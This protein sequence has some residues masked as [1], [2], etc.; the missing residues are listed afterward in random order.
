MT[1]IPFNSNLSNIKVY[2]T[3]KWNYGPEDLDLNGSVGSVISGDS[4]PKA[5]LFVRAKPAIEGEVNPAVIQFPSGGTLVPQNLLEY[6]GFNQLSNTSRDTINTGLNVDGA[7][8]KI[9]IIDSYGSQWVQQDLDYFSQ[10]CGI[11]S[12]TI[13]IYPIGDYTDWDALKNDQALSAEALGWSLETALDVQYA[14]ALAPL[15]EINLYTTP[16][17][18][19][20]YIYAAIDH[21]INIL[22]V[23]VI[24][25][26]LGTTETSVFYDSNFD[27]VFNTLNTNIV[28]AAGD[29][30]VQVLYPASSPYV[31]SIGGTVL[32]GGTY[33]N[34]Y[35]TQGAYSESAWSGS[36]GGIST[37]NPRPDYQNNITITNS[38]TGRCV[39]D[40]AFCGG[41]LQWVVLTNTYDNTG[42]QS[43]WYRV[44]GTSASAP[45]W[46]AILA[47][48]HSAG[49]GNKNQR[50]IHSDLYSLWI[51]NSSYNF[52][53]ITVG[54]NGYPATIGFDFITGLGS[55]IVNHIIPSI[56]PTPT[57]TPT[58][59][60]TPT[61]TT[62]NTTTPTPSW[63]P[64]L[65]PSQTPTQTKTPTK[66]PITPKTTS[67]P[68]NTSTNG[69]LFLTPTPSN[70]PTK[71]PA[72]PKPTSTPTPTTTVT[73]TKGNQFL[74]PTPSNTPT[75]TP[76]TPKPTSTRTPTPTKTVTPTRTK[77]LAFTPTATNTP[78]QTKTP[79]RTSLPTKTPTP[80]RT[81]TTTQTPSPLSLTSKPS[82]Y[83]RVAT[84]NYYSV[85][86]AS[87]ASIGLNPRYINRNFSEISIWDNGRYAGGT[88]NFTTSAVSAVKTF[89][90]VVYA[91]QAAPTTLFNLKAYDSDSNTVYDII[92]RFIF[93]AG[94]QLGSAA[95]PVTF[96]APLSALNSVPITQTPTPTN[97]PTNT[98]TPT[99]TQ[100]QT[101]TTSNTPTPTPTNTLTPTS[102]PSPTLTQ[103]STPT[104]TNTQTPTSTQTPTPTNT[105]TPSNTPTKAPI[106]SQ[107]PTNTPT[108]SG[109]P[110]PTPTVT[111]TPTPTVTPTVTNTQ[112]PTNT[113]TPTPTNTSTPTPTVIPLNL[114]NKPNWTRTSFQVSSTEV[115]YI[116]VFDNQQGI[117]VN[118]NASELSFWDSNNIC[119][120][121]GSI[122]TNVSST[123]YFAFPVYGAT[124][125]TVYTVKAYDAKTNTI[126]NI[127]ETLSFK[128]GIVFGSL[129]S[130]VDYHIALINPTQTPTA[131]STPTNTP[132]R[133]AEPTY[134]PTPTQTST[135]TPTNTP[136]QTRTQPIIL[137]SQT[138]TNTPTP[139][140]SNTPTPTKSPG[141]T[142]YLTPTRT[143][144]STPTSSRYPLPT[145]T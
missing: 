117:Y 71:T 138:P 1:I 114:S 134:T 3:I 73:P 124:D 112:T 96:H 82:W 7:G 90:F 84:G 59:T 58:N 80:T 144:T 128:S 30:G 12:T 19:W 88:G 31:L 123:P 41:S 21:A 38:P 109:T 48:R 81:P 95:S 78:T 141:S 24:S 77:T 57:P 65:T 86:Y 74:T 137:L 28:A 115:V 116:R 103:T 104:P 83:T 37:I 45:A 11:D 106:N 34:Y 47:R 13:N 18:D 36:G 44:Y 25:L 87:V 26:S 70:T 92:E 69:N 53:D 120:A 29:W 145:A 22:N 101:S 23:D 99:P 102:S 125:G 113:K 94:F 52:K 60:S 121:T 118:T 76:A 50:T 110:T 131:T 135:L 56:N 32:T 132:T 119:R 140:N 9:A 51:S 75:K 15:A 64:G 85:I 105:K 6:Y 63:T 97:R 55:P 122:T 139:T 133:T 4:L 107:T 91:N 8:A 66:T 43:G 129:T 5:Q 108:S 49:Y 20:N 14:H 46:A 27:D 100:T 89:A 35:S 127:L 39:P 98:P 62:T 54:N 142:P 93:K 111:S 10:A 16:V 68:T 67:T 130:P 2:P 42:L 136:T 40:V 61:N 17:N 72:T 33:P 79:T 143:G 126:Y